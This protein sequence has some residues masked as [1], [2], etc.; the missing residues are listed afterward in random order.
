MG[1]YATENDYPRQLEG[2]DVSDFTGYFFQIDHCGKH[3]NFIK[4][5]NGLVIK[6]YLADGD[7]NDLDFRGGGNGRCPSAAGGNSRK[8]P[9][10][11]ISPGSVATNGDDSDGGDN[12]QSGG[13]IEG[14][15]SIIGPNTSVYWSGFGNFGSN[16]FGGG[17]TAGTGSTLSQYFNNQIFN[18]TH[19]PAKV[20]LIEQFKTNQG[21]N[22]PISLLMLIIN[23]YCF[24]EPE[25]FD[26]CALWSMV[27][28]IDENIDLG[29][30]RTLIEG[31][32]EMI[33]SI[34]RLMLMADE[35]GLSSEDAK[36][37]VERWIDNDGGYVEIRPINYNTAN[38]QERVEHIHKWLRYIQWFQRCN[39]TFCCPYYALRPVTSQDPPGPTVVSYFFNNFTQGGLGT[40]LNGTIRYLLPINTLVPIKIELTHWSQPRFQIS[41]IGPIQISS[42]EN[43]SKFAY[44]KYQ[45]SGQ[46]AATISLYFPTSEE[47]NFVKDFIDRP[48]R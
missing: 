31:N 36:Y 44:P 21:I 8:P 11:W 9:R 39:P 29:E 10:R 24:D 19:D 40:T 27:N 43:N 6:R 1:Y 26:D 23:A 38:D 37:V 7:F 22:L 48:C 32:P 30:R 20:Q 14:G 35:S 17:G 4:I 34:I 45:S 28:W 15:G 42:I 16:N 47:P 12:T 18:Q 25:S 46:A 5:Q 41:P 2:F 3:S 33:E 13:D